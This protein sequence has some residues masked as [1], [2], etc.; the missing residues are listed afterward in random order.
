LGLPIITLT[1]DWQQQDYYSG[2]LKGRL[3]SLIP[4]ANIIENTNQI[5]AFHTFES[6][7]LLR[8]LVF[9]YPEGTIHLML[10]NQ[11]HKPEVFPI[12]VEFRGQF[13][14][15]WEDAVHGLVFDS[16]QAQSVRVN[17]EVFLEIRK[18]LNMKNV[19]VPPSFPALGF[20]PVLAK[21]LAEFKIDQLHKYAVKITANSPWLP[22]VEDN[23]ISGRI[24]YI[25]SYENA[26]SNISH[27]LFDKVGLGRRFEIF[28]KSKHYKLNTI[29]HGYMETEPGDL[30][31]LFNSINFLEVAIVHGS[32]GSLLGL[33]TGSAIKI[34]FY[35][36]A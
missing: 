33:E 14:V 3:L 26:I 34:Q 10:V 18:A 9:A 16:D 32:A 5:E 21:Y 7:F 22:V 29:N 25:D 8:Q 2:M 36:G 30:M 13:V 27:E 4:L 11:G 23:S 15:A 20:F 17:P 28:V 6:A 12:I 24:I 35:E 19:E 1:T 31:A